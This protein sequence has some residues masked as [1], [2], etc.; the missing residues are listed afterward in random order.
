MQGELNWNIC[1]GV[2]WNGKGE[3]ILKRLFGIFYSSKK[4][5]QKINQ[6]QGQWQICSTVVPQVELFSF[7]FWKNWHQKDISKLTDL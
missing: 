6:I 4:K 1:V 5:E 7:I 3:L 2:P